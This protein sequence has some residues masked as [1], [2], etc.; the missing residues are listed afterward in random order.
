[1]N[2]KRRQFLARTASAGMAATLAGCVNTLSAQGRRPNIL[3][4]MS[5]DHAAQGIGAY[6]GRLAE[7]NP[8]PRLDRLAA[9]GTLFEQVFVHNS[10]CTPSRATILTGQYSQSNGVLD[11]DGSIPASR[12]DLAIA[13]RR[14]GYQTAVIGK[15]HLKEEP[16]AFDFY[17]VLDNQGTYF[18]PVLF[19][20]GPRPWGENVQHTKGHSTDVITDESIAWLRGR[21][22]ERP[23]F[24]MHHYKAP[25]DP[26]DYAPRYESYLADVD[27]PEPVDLYRRPDT[28]G[29]IATRG[30][31][32]SLVHQIG[33]SVSKRHTLRNQGMHLGIDQNLPE[34]EYTRQ[35]YQ[36]YLKA[37]LR[38]IRGIDDNLARLFTYLEESGQWENTIVIY[39]SDQGFMTGEHDL[40]D[41]RWMYEES[42]KM[43]FILRHPR[44][45][46]QVKRSDILVNNTDFAP[47]MIELAG[48]SVPETMQGRSFVPALS[49]VTPPGWRTATYYRYWMH[50][51]HHDV[52]AHF[53][54]RTKRHK[55]IFFYGRHYLDNPPATFSS[56]A[57]GK[58]VRVYPQPS[59]IETPKA[60]ELY[61]LEK[62]PQELNNVYGDPAYVGVVRE[63][64]AE[65]KR[66]RAVYN[67]TDA[68]YPRLQAIIDQYWDS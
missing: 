33:T 58:P 50:R 65:L 45:T 5:D 64:K 21:K 38:C 25:H 51:A 34:P 1:M 22:D 7:L 18:D 12:Q 40:I 8:T 55:L 52:P 44:M 47:T 66:Q 61:D 3:F 56:H 2:M 13:M 67:E 4:I 28:W 24:L 26:F 10:I 57:S 14:A 20:R 19:M 6:G 53:G 35:S 49:G 30:P 39:T 68:N 11:L 60:W 17:K 31:G 54:V 23:F 37:Y 27:I 59:T 36:T 41:K 9:E 43:P 16:G 62:D 29:S 63:L 32:D 46:K 48:G 15:W 42:M